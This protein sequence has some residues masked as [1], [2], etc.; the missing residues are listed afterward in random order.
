MVLNTGPLDWKSSILTTRPLLACYSSS[1]PR[2]VKSPSNSLRY[3][4]QKICSW[5]RT[6]KT[7][8]EIRKWPY[9]SRWSTILLFT[10]FSRTLLTT[11][12]A[13]TGIWFL[14]VDLSPT[15]LNTETNDETF[16]QSG[17]QDTRLFQTLVEEFSKHVRKFRLTVL[18]N[19]H[20]N[21]IRTRGLQWI[22]V[23]YALINQGSL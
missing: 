22:K 20:W 14:A 16:Q 7:I 17:K 2:P 3:N 18:Y 12:R 6:S 4:C 1:S 21:T 11:K 23:C 19:H 9:F 8:L 13:L 15:F 10:S 5:L